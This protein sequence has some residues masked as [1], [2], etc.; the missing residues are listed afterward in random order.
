MSDRY[1]IKLSSVV[2]FLVMTD[3]SADTPGVMVR[4]FEPHNIDSYVLMC[5]ES[6]DDILQGEEIIYGTFVTDLNFQVNKLTRYY[7]GVYDSCLYVF[8]CRFLIDPH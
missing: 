4:V 6:T 5:P 7:E 3:T 1:H 8:V 2:N